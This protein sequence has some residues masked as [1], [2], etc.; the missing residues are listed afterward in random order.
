MTEATQQKI[1]LVCAH[2]NTINQFPVTRLDD[3]PICASCKQPLF[4]QKPIE[5]DANG[6]I[7]HIDNSGVP[8]LVD[9]WA[10]WCGPCQ[11]F[12]PVFNQ[13][14][15]AVGNQMRL[16]KVNTE[17]HQQAA[18]DFNI[19]SIPTLALFRDGREVARMSGALPLPQLQ[20]WVVEQL[21]QGN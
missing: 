11:N 3:M 20:Q 14:A 8:V 18:M 19:R 15:T 13:F 4:N 17:T 6:L 1:R 5:T 2:C 16:L 21:T 7:R 10:P 9:F 12:A